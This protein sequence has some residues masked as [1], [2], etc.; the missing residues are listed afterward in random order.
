MQNSAAR[1]ANGEC[2]VVAETVFLEE[3]L[4]GLDRLLGDL[5]NR[6]LHAAS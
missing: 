5:V 6:P 2:V 4:A 1:E 3:W